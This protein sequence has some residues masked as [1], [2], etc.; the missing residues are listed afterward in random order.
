MGFREIFSGA[1]LLVAGEIP[2]GIY[3]LMGPSGAGK[4]VF[5]KSFLINGFS[6]QEPGIYLSTDEDCERIQVSIRSLIED[7]NT[8]NSNLKLVDAYSWRLGGAIDR[9]FVTVNPANLSEVSIAC[10]TVCKGLSKPRFVLDSISSLV[11]HSNPDTA[12]KF[13]QV[14]T[15]K[16]RRMDALS[17]FTITPASHDNRFLSM[18]KS[19][20]DGIFEMR[21]DETGWEFARMFRIFSIKGVQ[22]K[23]H[24][25]LYAINEKGGSL[26]EDSTPR[27][28]WCGGVIEYDP[29]KVSIEGRN[30]T[31]HAPE[32]E[33]K[34]RKRL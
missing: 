31:F 29:H 9:P 28:A 17:I 21:L 13:L 24:W 32:C 2:R 12:L 1:A 6:N 22:H 33:A 5:C 18:V 15:A 8:V 7:Q 30:Y 19:M 16:I 3:L 10:D 34:F 23:T 14:I 25:V 26:V 4:T 11:A 20:F 27:C